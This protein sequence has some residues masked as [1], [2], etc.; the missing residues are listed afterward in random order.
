MPRSRAP[1]S[2]PTRVQGATRAVLMTTTLMP[3]RLEGH[4]WDLSAA[5]FDLVS[6]FTRIKIT[7]TPAKESGREIVSRAGSVARWRSDHGGRVHIVRLDRRRGSIADPEETCSPEAKCRVT[8]N[9]A[10]REGSL[11]R[12]SGLGGRNI[13]GQSGG[14]VG[15]DGDVTRI[16]AC[17]TSVGRSIF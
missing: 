6:P 3:D 4:R 10:A 16:A 14:P 1:P 9:F 17:S 5:L 15:Q 8:C 2:S 7:T 12:G 11:P 13:A